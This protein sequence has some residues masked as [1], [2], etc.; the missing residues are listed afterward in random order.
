MIWD[1]TLSFINEIDFNRQKIP[2]RLLASTTKRG[3]SDTLELIT[4]T[5]KKNGYLYVTE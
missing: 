1:E 4:T 2:D 3:V 5:W